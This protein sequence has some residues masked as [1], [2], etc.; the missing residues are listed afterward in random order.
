MDLPSYES[1][2]HGTFD[3]EQQISPKPHTSVLPFVPHFRSHSVIGIYKASYPHLLLANSSHDPNP[4]AYVSTHSWTRPHLELHRTGA[5]NSP[6][7]ATVE[8]HVFSSSTTISVPGASM[9]ESLEKEGIFT[10]AFSFQMLHPTSGKREVFEWRSSSGPQVRALGG[11]RRG[12]KL[13]RVAT[14]EVIVVYAAASFSLEK[15]GKMQWLAEE[16]YGD[17]GELIIMMSLLALVEK[18]RR[19][20]RSSAGGVVQQDR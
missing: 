5:Q 20:N 11:Q 12:I 6:V 8:F 2:V 16:S 3:L 13:V 15:V 7:L 14:G 1:V 4:I 17:L 19:D 9:S 18:S 10:P